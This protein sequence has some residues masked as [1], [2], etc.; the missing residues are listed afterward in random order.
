MLRRL[1]KTT[2]QRELEQRISFRRGRLQIEKSVAAI[3][4]QRERYMVMGRAAVANGSTDKVREIAR[5]IQQCNDLERRMT[6]ALGSLDLWQQQQD[7]AGAQ[8][9]FAAAMQDS[10]GMIQDVQATEAL[11][12]MDLSI[13]EAE[14]ANDEIELLTQ[15]FLEG[16]LPVRAEDAEE[17]A[18]LEAELNAAMHEA[19]EASAEPS[20][21]E[22]E[23]EESD[24]SA[25]E[26]IE[27]DLKELEREL[28]LAV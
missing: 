1:F 16:A 20:R 9:Q 24:R 12:Q 14:T 7:I 8:R 4:R 21:R 23:G 22:V 27:I 10:R 11:A 18:A 2:K 26:P 17:R 13:R 6:T 25:P 5:A 3:A 19:P 28:N 15:S